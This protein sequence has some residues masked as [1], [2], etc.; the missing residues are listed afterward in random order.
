MIDASVLELNAS[1]VK[2]LYT[3][4][5]EVYGKSK[6]AGYFEAK[7]NTNYLGNMPAGF[8]MMEGKKPLAFA[9]LIPAH[10]SV[11]GKTALGF[12][13][14]DTMTIAAARKKGYCT[15]LM[16]LALDKAAKQG[17]AFAYGFANED[18]FHWLTKKA[19]YS[20]HHTLQRFTFSFADDLYKKVRRKLLRLPSQRPSALNNA[21]IA[22]GHDGCLYSKGFIEYKKY[23]NNFFTN[24]D[25]PNLWLSARGAYLGAV[26]PGSDPENAI[27]RIRRQYFLKSLSV[28]VSPGTG[29]ST[30]LAR[31]VSPEE[32]FYIVTKV[33]D[34]SRTLEDLKLQLADADIF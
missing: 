10:F 13:S 7:Y 29:I 1:S 24:A 32:G 27:E 15:T 18:S 14:C 31:L 23:N 3:L 26:S 33:L 8:F 4:T 5:R 30:G 2:H 17:G 21:L 22:A 12:Q 6:P 11:K 19:G 16:Q 34:N 9:G 20:H 28:M 25:G